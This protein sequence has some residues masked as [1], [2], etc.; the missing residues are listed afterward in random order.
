[1]K[2]S[3]PDN[4]IAMKFMEMKQLVYKLQ[5]YLKKYDFCE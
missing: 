3:I 1:M 4:V 2:K 5:I